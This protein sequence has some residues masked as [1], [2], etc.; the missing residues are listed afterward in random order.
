[1]SITPDSD[2][3][4]T[5]PSQSPLS[6]RQVVLPPDRRY[7]YIPLGRLAGCLTFGLLFLAFSY[8]GVSGLETIGNWLNPNFS[9]PNAFV[10]SHAE[11]YVVIA[12]MILAVST[13]LIGLLVMIWICM[14]MYRA[15]ANLRARGLKGLETSPGMC[16]GW[17][18]VPIANLLKPYHAMKEI[19]QGSLHIGSSDWDRKDVPAVFGLW[20]FGWIFGNVIARFE[21]QSTLQGMDL[22]PWLLVVSWASSILLFMSSVCLVSIVRQIRE[23]Q[24][25]F[26]EGSKAPSVETPFKKSPGTAY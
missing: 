23:H 4:Y 19:Y 9:D 16:G 26:A 1:M 21:S 12:I 20:W 6:R 2:P 3:P 22:G 13:L 7:Q 25:N 8:A 17:W 15:N 24:D 18:F 11:Q 14:F 10:T 5:V